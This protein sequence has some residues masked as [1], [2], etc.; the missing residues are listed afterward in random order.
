M[1]TLSVKFVL[2]RMRPKRIVS[3]G[4]AGCGWRPT[5][6]VHSDCHN[7]LMYPTFTPTRDTS[8]LG[9]LAST[10]SC[11][12]RERWTQDPRHAQEVTRQLLHLPQN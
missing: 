10:G 1:G 7:P 5:T 8:E 6:T 4:M 9:R 2:A 11:G 3:C 12:V